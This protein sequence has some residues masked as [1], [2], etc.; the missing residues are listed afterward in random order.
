M[1]IMVPPS[2]HISPPFHRVSMPPLDALQAFVA[3]VRDVKTKTK[4]GRLYAC[5]SLKTQEPRS[6][7]SITQGTPLSRPLPQ[8][9]PPSI[10]PSSCPPDPTP[11]HPPHRGAG[12]ERGQLCVIPGFAGHSGRK[13]TGMCFV[14]G[15]SLCRPLLPPI[16]VT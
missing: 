5:L 8:S 6:L 15:I 7:P 13:C 16:K 2:H 4:Q 3:P 14:L 11:T 1:H 9:I 12:P 10:T